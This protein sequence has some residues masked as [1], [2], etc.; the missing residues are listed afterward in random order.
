ME[1]RDQRLDDGDGAVLGA[2]V[3][4]RLE[5]VRAVEVPARPLAGL[6]DERREVDAG[7]HLGERGG[8]VGVRRRVEDRVAAEDQRRVDLAALHRS[9][10]LDQRRRALWSLLNGATQRTGAASAR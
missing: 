9:G 5:P 7:R 1:R 6:V 3:A 10:E 8:E 2:H 4:P